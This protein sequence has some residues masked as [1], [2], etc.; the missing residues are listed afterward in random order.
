M[1]AQATLSS[2]FVHNQILRSRHRHRRHHQ[3]AFSRS[4]S[5]SHPPTEHDVINIFSII[6]PGASITHSRKFV[7]FMSYPD[8]ETRSEDDPT[9]KSPQHPLNAVV[10]VVVIG[11]GAAGLQAAAELLRNDP[12]LS[13]TI[14]EARDRIGGRIWTTRESVQTVDGETTELVRDLGAAWIHG[15][16]GVH[17][18]EVNPMID[19]LN[20]VKD[21]TKKS[22]LY[23]VFP[24][25]AWTRPD[26]VLHRTGSIALYV[27]GKEISIESPAVSQ[28]IQLHYDMLRSMSQYANTLFESGEGS[29][30]DELSVKEVMTK[31][32]EDDDA[33][34][35][36][37]ETDGLVDALVPFYLFLVENW[38]GVSIRDTQLSLL[39][40]ADD[41][42]DAEKDKTAPMITD[43]R[44][45]CEGDYDGPHCKL[46]CGMATILE[47]LFE[48]IG[49]DKIYLNE[50]V[51]SVVNLDSQGVRVDTASGRVVHT[52]C[53]VSTIPL[54]CLQETA[55]DVF[56][57]KL[58]EGKMEAIHSIWSGSYKK[59]FLTFDYIFWPK[60]VPL[61]GLIRQTIPSSS[62]PLLG[63]HLLLTNLFAKDGIPSLEA[64]L[65]G[66]MGKWAFQKSDEVIRMEV[67]DF[68]GSCMGISNLSESCVGC[69]I[70]RWEEDEYT[71]GSYSTFRLGTKERHVDALAAPEWDGKLMF[72]G[73]PTESENMGSVH[74]A[75]TSGR[76]AADEVLRYLRS[77]DQ[78][79]KIQKF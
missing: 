36:A 18:Q 8:A 20:M 49:K 27:D 25:N 24:G 55:K 22:S 15:T 43:E 74:A 5:A 39:L 57:P 56:S 38:N 6:T 16:G 11:A 1:R 70:T 75:L 73:E 44:Y 19:L 29:K 28:A 68:I 31:I 64:V 66:D 17:G 52:K 35:Y 3:R 47:P 4:S 71:R 41:S 9:T 53:C 46:R 72:A 61:I 48:T 12:N 58:S 69:H 67:L 65:C 63:K 23:Q 50:K 59:V 21:D 32:R 54:G 45:T 26:T 79:S 62:D 76:R 2:V 33:R 30:I 13:V 34:K 77:K 7:S 51:V 60:L 42:D 10:N 40:A 78:I 14:L 37:R